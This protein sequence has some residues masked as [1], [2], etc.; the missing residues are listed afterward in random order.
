MRTIKYNESVEKDLQQKKLIMDKTAPLTGNIFLDKPWISNYPEKP[1]KVIDTKE[2]LYKT[3]KEASKGR[4]KE[5]A[6]II[7]DTE[8]VYTHEELL[9]LIDAT[10]N[11]LTKYGIGPNSIIG[12]MLNNTIEEPVFCLPQVN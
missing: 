4:E 3:Y 7:P 8:E 12:A 5:I 10:A 9:S 1:I 11:A 2:T 6:I